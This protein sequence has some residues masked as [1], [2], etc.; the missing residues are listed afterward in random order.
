MDKVIEKNQASWVET[1]KPNAS[2]L[3]VWLK[4]LKFI[5]CRADQ[6]YQETVVFFTV[7]IGRHVFFRRQV[8]QL[9]FSRLN[10]LANNLT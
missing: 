9:S 5:I 3:F 8:S 4:G 1:G 6:K 2:L 7:S 10:F